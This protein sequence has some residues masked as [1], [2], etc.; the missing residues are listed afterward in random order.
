MKMYDDRSVSREHKSE[1]KQKGTKNSCH[2]W[3]VLGSLLFGSLA[4]IVLGG[5]VPPVC[6][7]S[8]V[9]SR[10]SRRHRTLAIG[11]P[12]VPCSVGPFFLRKLQI[13]MK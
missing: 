2:S 7:F 1:L 10:C 11:L 3:P 9:E 12:F 5:F 6:G 13:I 8:A 4:L